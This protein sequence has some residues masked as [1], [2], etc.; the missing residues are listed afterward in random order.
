MKTNFFKNH[1]KSSLNINII[2]KYKN[3][4]FCL[5]FDALKKLNMINKSILNL[6][7]KNLF[8]DTR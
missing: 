6:K 4:I 8:S 2:R 1:I 5:T 3:K 7:K